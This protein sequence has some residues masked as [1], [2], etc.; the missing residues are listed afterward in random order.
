M[1]CNILLIS[2]R[3]RENCVAFGDVDE[4]RQVVLW[5]MVLHHVRPVVIE[6]LNKKRGCPPALNKI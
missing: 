1:N 3:N 6:S 4:K 5:S 2:R